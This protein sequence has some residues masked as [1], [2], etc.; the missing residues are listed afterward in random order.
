MLRVVPGEAAVIGEVEVH[1]L[2][3]LKGQ[4]EGGTEGVPVGP[5][6]VDREGGEGIAGKGG[7]KG[8]VVVCEFVVPGHFAFRIEPIAEK[9]PVSPATKKRDQA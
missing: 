1:V 7:V 2:L 4:P 6:S 5:V 3:R 9:L 8:V